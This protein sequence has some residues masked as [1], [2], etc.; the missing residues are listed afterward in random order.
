MLMMIRQDGRFLSDRLRRLAWP[1]KEFE[2]EW[3]IYQMY[4]GIE[5]VNLC[6]NQ[7]VAIKSMQ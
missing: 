7:V 6:V 2:T 3:P 5:E 4:V 1:Y